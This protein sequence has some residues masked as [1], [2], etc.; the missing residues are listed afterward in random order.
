MSHHHGV[1]LLK[2]DALRA[3]QGPLHERVFRPIKRALDP[4]DLLNPGK[5]GLT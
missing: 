3:A 5:L 1:G 4:Q 2:G